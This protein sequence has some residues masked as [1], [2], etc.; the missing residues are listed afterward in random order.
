MKETL[1]L[2]IPV[3]ITFNVDPGQKTTHWEPGFP[4][5]IED[6]CFDLNQVQNA[7]QDYL[8]DKEDLVDAELMQLVRQKKMANEEY[9]ADLKYNEMKGE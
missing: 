3:E 1:Y 9:L 2:E 5:S 6:K 4:P 7:V 8:K